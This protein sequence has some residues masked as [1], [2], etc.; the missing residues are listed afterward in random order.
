M[1]KLCL[2]HPE[3]VECQGTSNKNVEVERV[4]HRRE[5]V[6]E[7]EPTPRRLRV[8]R[9]HDTKAHKTGAKDTHMLATRKRLSRDATGGDDESMINTTMTR[10]KRR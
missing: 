9:S 3:T 4:V 2:V 1:K 8:P 6:D 7:G 5:E 10:A